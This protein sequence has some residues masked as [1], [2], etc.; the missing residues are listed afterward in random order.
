VL[1]NINENNQEHTRRLLHCLAVAVRPLRI[2]ELAEILALDFDVAQGGIPKFRQNL[3]LEDQ[4]EDVLSICSSLITVVDNR[5]SRVVQFSHMS[6][7]EFLTSNH[8]KISTGNLSTYQILPGHAHTILAQACL[9]LL[10]DLDD[11]NDNNVKDTPLA[12]YA[13]QHWVTHAQFE[14]VASRVEDGMKSLFDNEKPHFSAWTRLYDPYTESGGKLPL[15]GRSP[16]YYSALSGF[17]DLSR[18]I[19][20]KYPPEVNAIGGPFGFPLVAALRSDNFRMAQ[21]LLE[22]GGN[23]VLKCCLHTRQRLNVGGTRPYSR[24]R[25]E[26]GERY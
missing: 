23:I 2:E 21:L 9:G 25:D 11:G 26:M 20:V 8:L 16:L 17:Y 5:G 13:A 24:G 12:L 1:N 4:E 7:K 10:L 14:D 15:G 6:V 22:Q 18:Q 3:S 19:A